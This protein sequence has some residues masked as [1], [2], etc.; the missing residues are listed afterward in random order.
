[1]NTTPRSIAPNEEGW[2]GQIFVGDKWLDYARGYEAESKAWQAANPT[3]RRL[4]HW[5]TREILVPNKE[6]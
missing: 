1:M 4:V 6:A 2:L 5:I 3:K